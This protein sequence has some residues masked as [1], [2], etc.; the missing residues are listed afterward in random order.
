MA[1]ILNILHNHAKILQESS[2]DLCTISGK[3]YATYL[4]KFLPLIHT[5]YVPCQIMQ[6]T[7]KDCQLQCASKIIHDHAVS[8]HIFARALTNK[9]N[10]K[11]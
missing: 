2:Q 8:G 4:G 1:D 7:W 9:L 5:H 3:I 11:W 10:G 6:E